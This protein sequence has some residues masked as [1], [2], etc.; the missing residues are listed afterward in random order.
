VGA[1]IAGL[2]SFLNRHIGWQSS[3]LVLPPVYLMYRSYRLYLGKL[4]DETRHAEQVSNLHLR[5]IE[6]LAL[7]IEAKDHTTHDHLQR[8]R[9]YAM[10]IAKDSLSSEDDT[11]ALQRR[12]FCMTLE[13]WPFLSTSSPSPENLRL[14]SSRR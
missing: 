1:A 13:N 14:K 8:V 6:A 10:E 3:L 4:E 9:V 7:A 12:R 5:T 11:E 2:V